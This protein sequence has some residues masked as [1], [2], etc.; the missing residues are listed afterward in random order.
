MITKRTIISIQERID[1]ARSSLI[2][3]FYDGKPSLKA[4]E[5]IIGRDID[6]ARKDLDYVF[7]LAD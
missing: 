3:L 7:S 1:S 2:Q 5:E 6:P 4:I